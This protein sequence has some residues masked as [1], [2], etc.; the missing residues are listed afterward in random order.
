MILFL[1]SYL[2]I[3]YLIQL[4]ILMFFHLDVIH[5]LFKVP[6][7]I[8]SSYFDVLVLLLNLFFFF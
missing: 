2:E 5:I 6:E 4:F 7:H 8:H 3:H 1:L